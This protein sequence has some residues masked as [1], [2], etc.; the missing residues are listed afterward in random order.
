MIYI[1]MYKYDTHI[2][3][4]V[5]NIYNCNSIYL[6]NHKKSNYNLDF[7]VKFPWTVCDIYVKH[8]PKARTET[9]ELQQ[10]RNGHNLVKL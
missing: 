2:H 5:T 1:Y 10:K 6:S 9:D 7:L 8:F 3:I 4:Y